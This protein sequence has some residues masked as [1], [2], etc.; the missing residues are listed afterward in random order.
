MRL[1]RF[2]ILAPIF[3]STFFYSTLNGRAQQLEPSVSSS[4]TSLHISQY[5][6]LFNKAILRPQK[7]VYKYN[8]PADLI[9][10]VPILRD[11]N[12]MIPR[13]FSFADQEVRLDP[14]R[15]T[16]QHQWLDARARKTPKTSIISMSWSSSSGGLFSS[17]LDVPLFYS[18]TLGFSDWSMYP[19]GNY[20]MT[21]N[22]NEFLEVEKSFYIRALT[23]F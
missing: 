22:R 14:R 20:T 10:L 11:I 1:S 18:G 12:R 3:L 2:H 21:L 13:Q 15:I 6:I 5:R 8:E 4:T 23:R 16:I 7:E 9:E 19:L 17:K